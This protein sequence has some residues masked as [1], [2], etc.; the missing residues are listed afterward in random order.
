MSGDRIESA[1]PGEHLREFLEEYGLARQQLAQ[2]I[3]VPPQRIDE[4]IQGR[5]AV[6]AD[7]ALRLARYFGT[8]A[9]YWMNLQAGYDLEVAKASVDLEAIRPLA[10]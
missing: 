4:I 10:A 2:G 6:T 1:H 8:T 5:E 9:Q 7:T 3:H